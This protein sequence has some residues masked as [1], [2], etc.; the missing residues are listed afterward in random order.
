[1]ASRSCGSTTVKKHLRR[2][3]AE[4]R[5]DVLERR[6]E[7]AEL[8]DDRQVDQREIGEHRDATAGQRPRSS[9]KLLSQA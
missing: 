8:R 7:A 3:L 4:R 9:G 5:R 1:M 6:I 2:R